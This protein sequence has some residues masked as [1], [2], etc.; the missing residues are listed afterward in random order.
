MLKAA[1]PC[2]WLVVAEDEERVCSHP[3]AVPTL[4]VCSHAPHWTVC[5]ARL[6]DE[7]L[8]PMLE[9]I[10]LGLLDTKGVPA[11]VEWMLWS[12]LPEEGAVN[13]LVRS[14][15]KKARE[16]AAVNTVCCAVIVILRPQ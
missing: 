12:N 6:A 16:K 14:I 4:Q 11:L 3:L 1:V 7:D 10:C 2:K 13:S 8:C 15:P 5:T 9:L